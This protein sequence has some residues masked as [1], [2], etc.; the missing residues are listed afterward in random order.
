MNLQTR[1]SYPCS[2]S[3]KVEHLIHQGSNDIVD[4]GLTLW[5]QLDNRIQQGILVPALQWWDNN[6]L[7]GIIS[8]ETNQLGSSSR[9]NIE[10]DSSHSLGSSGAHSTALEQRSLDK[11]ILL[12][13]M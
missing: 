2:Y 10:W 11:N 4:R 8:V 7:L 3:L 6:S 9:E 5:I 1:Y 12:G 13:R